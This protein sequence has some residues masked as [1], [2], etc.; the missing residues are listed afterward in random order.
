MQYVKYA[1]RKSRSEKAKSGRGA[2]TFSLGGMN[3]IS[4]FTVAP[5]I[6]DDRVNK[7]PDERRRNAHEDQPDIA[8]AIGISWGRFWLRARHRAT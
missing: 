8:Q 1:W 5:A 2:F 7:I 6:A 3:T 4:S